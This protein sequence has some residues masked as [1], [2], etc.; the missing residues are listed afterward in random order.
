VNKI[1]PLLT[2]HDSPLMGQIAIRT[3]N[4]VPLQAQDKLTGKA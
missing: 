1:S 2:I 4:A 3:M